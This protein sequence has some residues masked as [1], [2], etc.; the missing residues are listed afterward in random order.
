MLLHRLTDMQR[1][2]DAHG[3]DVRPLVFQP[4]ATEP[5]VKA[6]EAML[7]LSLPGSFRRVLLNVSAHIEFR[8]FM[9][10]GMTL[11]EPFESNF[12]GD[13]HWSLKLTEECDQNK[14]G[15]I[16]QVFPNRGDP[17]DAVWWD[18]LAFYEI[19]NG[20]LL[21]MDLR[22]ETYEQIVYL[23]HDDGE[24]HGYV[25]AE[26]FEALLARWIPVACAGGE[27]WQWLPFTESRTSMLDPQCGNARVF[28]SLLG[29]Q[30]NDGLEP[31][32]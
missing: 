20:D 14:Q 26:N 16:E 18:K 6:L 4:P 2:L 28:R 5:E 23:S 9:P 11:P 15:W 7:G 19:G 31:T 29:L 13:L 12:S 25:L 3:C 22:P 30:P 21:A 1:R 17:Y 27:D 8:W 10:E 32:R 24:G